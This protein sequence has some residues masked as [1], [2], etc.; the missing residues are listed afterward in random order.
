MALIDINTI[1]IALID[2]TS[3][4]NIFQK[5]LIGIAIN[6]F[7][8][9]L[10]GK[11][12]HR[13]F[14]L[15][16]HHLFRGEGGFDPCLVGLVLFS[17]TVSQHQ[18]PPPLQHQHLAH[19]DIIEGLEMLPSPYRLAKLYTGY[20]A[21]GYIARHTWLYSHWLFSHVYMAI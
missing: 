12:S 21:I 20:M 9:V 3:D 18:P 5:G 8:I 19:A 13:I 2:I 10:I 11:T 15:N 7:K 6:I 1:M 16:G 14:F 4:I 17:L